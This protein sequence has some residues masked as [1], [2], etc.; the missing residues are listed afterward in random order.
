MEFSS[1]IST[2]ESNE[3]IRLVKQAKDKL[4]L[5]GPRKNGLFVCAY[6]PKLDK[7]PTIAC[8]MYYDQSVRTESFIYGN[9]PRRQCFMV[10][11]V[12]I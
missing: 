2:D 5:G 12:G 11:Q 10:R 7:S 6:H 9:Q 4:V 1:I 3:K 8:T